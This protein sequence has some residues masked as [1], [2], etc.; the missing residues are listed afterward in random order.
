MILCC[1]MVWGVGEENN[2]LVEGLQLWSQP[3][4]SGKGPAFVFRSCCF[5]RADNQRWTVTANHDSRGICTTWSFCE[6]PMWWQS[7]GPWGAGYG[8]G[9]CQGMFS[10]K[11]S[12]MLFSSFV[13]SFSR[14]LFLI[15]SWKTGMSGAARSSQDWDHEKRHLLGFLSVT[16]FSDS[17]QWPFT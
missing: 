5:T 10:F 8:V 14:T 1:H 6:E 12:N 11:G 15:S 16:P 7:L 2:R 17:L 4:S 3:D 9:K 13:C